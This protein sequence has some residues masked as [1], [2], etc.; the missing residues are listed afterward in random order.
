MGRRDIPIVLAT[1]VLVTFAPLSRAA[2]LAVADLGIAAFF[3][4][5]AALASVGPGAPW[6]VLGA[7]LLGIAFRA[8]D[9]V[10]VGQDEPVSREDE[11]RTA[12]S[13]S[14]GS[15]C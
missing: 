4:A 1:T 6:F 3:I 13:L 12:A 7:V 11:S 15:T 9:D 10:A 14:R 8:V 2:A 5:G